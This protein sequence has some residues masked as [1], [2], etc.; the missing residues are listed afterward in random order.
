MNLIRKKVKIIS[1]YYKDIE[2]IVEGVTIDG[3]WLVKPQSKNSFF[4]K[5]NDLIVI[6]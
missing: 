1:G 3:Y 6:D 4:A 2:G 5:T